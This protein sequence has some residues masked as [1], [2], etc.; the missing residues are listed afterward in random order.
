MH[1]NVSLS[2]VLRV[3]VPLPGGVRA[4][5]AASLS[6]CELRVCVHTQLCVAW[7]AGRSA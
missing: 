3:S 5:T 6:A 2:A 7:R 1:A 4:P